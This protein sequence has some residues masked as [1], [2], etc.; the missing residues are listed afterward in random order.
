MAIEESL[1]SRHWPLAAY[2]YET[3][4]QPPICYVGA[5]QII[6]QLLPPDKRQRFWHI[7]ETADADSCYCMAP[8]ATLLRG[9][10]W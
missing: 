8:R 9:K 4:T 5:V 1:A 6:L 7:G 3:P 10:L 2:R